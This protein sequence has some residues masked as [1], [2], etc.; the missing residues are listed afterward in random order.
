MKE[1]TRTAL[2][3]RFVELMEQFS[4]QMRSHLP[5]A[6]SDLELTMP[7]ARTLMLLG[8]GQARMRDI[9]AHLGCG[10][11]SAT[12]MIDRLVKKGLVERAED[13]SDRRAVACRLT[14]LGEEVVERF[15]RMGRVRF[16]ALADVLSERELQTVLPAMGVLA[17]ATARL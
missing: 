14:A 17:E 15:W 8:H 9:S 3:D 6:W 10:V 13:D 1:P 12:S 7:Q 2:V 4:A 5:V 16:E 11:S